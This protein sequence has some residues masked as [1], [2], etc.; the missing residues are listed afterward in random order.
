MATSEIVITKTE[1][2]PIYSTI[3]SSTTPS[4][5]IIIETIKTNR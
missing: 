1:I 4:R 3:G 5:Y 2:K